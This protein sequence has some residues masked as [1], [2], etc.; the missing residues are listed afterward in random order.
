MGIPNMDIFCI[1]NIPLVHHKIFW[2]DWNYIFL[3]F[4]MNV[5]KETYVCPRC[6]STNVSFDYS[7]EWR[8]ATGLFPM[9]CNKCGFIAMMFPIVKNR[10]Q[11]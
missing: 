7:I 9:R 6:G 8:N 2:S 1:L 3:S 11:I 4:I 5:M 10:K